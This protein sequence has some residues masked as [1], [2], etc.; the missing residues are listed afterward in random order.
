MRKKF[1]EPYK[2]T[3]I[4]DIWGIQRAREVFS[5]DYV[6]SE[7]ENTY[8]NPPRHKF[9]IYKMNQGRRQEGSDCP[10]LHPMSSNFVVFDDLLQ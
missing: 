10:Y 9:G 6:N 1:S 4:Q 5:T 8:G 2:I 7:Q 3:S